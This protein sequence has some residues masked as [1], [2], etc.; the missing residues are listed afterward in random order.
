[1]RLSGFGWKNLFKPFDESCT[2]NRDFQRNVSLFGRLTWQ[3]LWLTFALDHGSCLKV[4]GPQSHF[5]HTHTHTHTRT[6]THT[7]TRC[8]G[9]GVV[10]IK[11]SATSTSV[12]NHCLSSSP[13]HEAVVVRDPKSFHH[14][15]AICSCKDRISTFHIP[16]FKS[17]SRQTSWIETLLRLGA[18]ERSTKSRDRTSVPVLLLL[19]LTLDI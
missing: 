18:Q 15:I 4:G 5:H 9:D 12:K 6:H 8:F 14:I 16:F 11:I 1:M 7:H 17:E 3:L 2:G 19:H 13:E 10:D